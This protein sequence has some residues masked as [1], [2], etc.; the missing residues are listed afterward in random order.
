M[1]LEP[2]V[3]PDVLLAGHVR[4]VIADVADQIDES[5]VLGSGGLVTRQ[6]AQ[7]LLVLE[8]VQDPLRQHVHRFARAR[9]ADQ[10]EDDRPCSEKRSHPSRERWRDE[11][12]AAFGLRHGLPV[13]ISNRGDRDGVARRAYGSRSHS[14][15]THRSR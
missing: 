6:H 11:K 15:D 7:Y 13:P 4:G 2:A 12:R 3:A 5:E 1:R 14:G 8:G 9:Q 10:T